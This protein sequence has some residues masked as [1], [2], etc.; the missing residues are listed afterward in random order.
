MAAPSSKKLKT[1]LPT[2]TNHHELIGTRVKQNFP[3]IVEE[4]LCGAVTVRME[5]SYR[6]Q[7][8]AEIFEQD[9]VALPRVAG[10]FHREAEEELETAEAM[11]GYLRERGGQYCNK[12]I[13][14]PG[15][16]QV[17]NIIQ[18]LELTLA[19]WKKVSGYMEELCLLSK[20][21]R[22]HHTASVVK[23]RFVTRVV[24][25]IEGVGNVLTNARRLGCTHEGASG[26]GEY[27]IDQL[28]EEL[29]K[30]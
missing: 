9:H 22:D 25:K 17:C 27:L 23:K 28:Q 14:R 3:L 21:N 6:L 16:E 13:Q 10:Y 1:C 19:Q 20:E 12:D 2:C 7:A 15:C 8:L 26:F 5:L 30:N 11:M 24:S 4:S 18:A 29:G